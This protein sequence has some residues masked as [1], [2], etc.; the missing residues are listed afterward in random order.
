[1]NSRPADC[2]TAPPLNKR[3]SNLFNYLTVRHCQSLPAISH[4]LAQVQ[5]KGFLAVFLALMSFATR[6]PFNSLRFFTC[7]PIYV[8]RG[9]MVQ[10]SKLHIQAH[11]NG[12]LALR[13]IDTGAEVSTFRLSSARAFEPPAIAAHRANRDLIGHPG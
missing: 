12:K 6:S 3:S 8:R 7:L 5:C 9:V 11:V 10:N 1:L 4:R 2:E 13:H